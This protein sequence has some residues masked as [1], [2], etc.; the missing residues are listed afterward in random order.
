M[1]NENITISQALYKALTY[2]SHQARTVQE[3]QKYLEKKGICDDTIQT[4]IDIL[5]NKNYLNDR[6]FAKDFIETRIKTK[7]KSKFAFEYELRRK[8]IPLSVI[9]P[10]VQAYEDH[11]LALKAVE[12]K[13]NTWQYL[14]REKFKKKVM[15]FLRYRGF[16]YDICLSTL[17]HFLESNT[18]GM[19]GEDG[20]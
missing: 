8:G 2:L 11:A 12:S 20:N 16:S 15:N 17:N 13:I 4:A 3:M 9:E 7:P 5:Q 6:Q 14:D 19:G 18:F 10:L 1:V